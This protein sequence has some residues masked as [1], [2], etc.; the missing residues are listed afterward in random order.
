MERESC[1]E[2]NARQIF[3]ESSVPAEGLY[4]RIRNAAR[5]TDGWNQAPAEG[6]YR[7]IRR[8]P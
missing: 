3:G 5:Q 6:L 8:K 4:R 1:Q 2:K 7:Q